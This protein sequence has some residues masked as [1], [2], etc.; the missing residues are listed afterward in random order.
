MKNIK[1]IALLFAA[2]TW[3]LGCSDDPKTDKTTD[4]ET[5]STVDSEGVDG[6]DSDTDSPET[7]TGDA[8]SALRFT[9][10]SPTAPQVLADVASA[11]QTA[12]DN[13]DLNY[14]LV[15]DAPKEDGSIDAQIGIGEAVDGEDNTYSLGSDATQV[16][17]DMSGNEFTS[18]DIFDFTLVVP[19]P[20]ANMT[21]SVP[22]QEVT[23]TGAFES[24][25]HCA[26]GSRE[27]TDAAPTAGGEMSG[28]VTV[29]DADSVTLSVSIG[30]A[31]RSFTL[32]AY[33][34]YGMAGIMTKPDCS[35]GIDDFTNPPD[36]TTEGG[37]PAWRVTSDIA[38]AAITLQE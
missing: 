19:L 3:M 6:G 17:F 37:D 34:A 10:M 25:D 30:G 11:A 29:A 16:T 13:G 26:V 31:D 22:M 12:I 9:M 33:L 28:L 14:L 4:E 36:E 7:D 20:A 32:C 18:A 5:D 23:M 21:I 8:C 27:D 35:E 2:A 24:S 1:K 15:M 38:A